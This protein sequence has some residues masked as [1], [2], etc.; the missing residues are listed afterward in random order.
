MTND[1]LM[2]N[3][4]DFDHAGLPRDADVCVPRGAVG[5]NGSRA[6]DHAG[7][8]RGVGACILLGT[9]GC[10]TLHNSSIRESLG[11]GFGASPRRDP[12]TDAG[13]WALG[14][15]REKL[16]ISVSYTHLTL[17]TIYSV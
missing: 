13:L 17:P 5:R 15:R 2:L 9:V 7:P 16:F 3:T 4:R 12:T 8:M 1:D 11:A 14:A 10:D 6:G